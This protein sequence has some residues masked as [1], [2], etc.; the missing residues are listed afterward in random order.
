MEQ[1]K[2]LPFKIDF[3]VNPHGFPIWSVGLQLYSQIEVNVTFPL[4]K[5]SSIMGNFRCQMT[6]FVEIRNVIKKKC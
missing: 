4:M 5:I 1:Q 2:M 3:I 6:I